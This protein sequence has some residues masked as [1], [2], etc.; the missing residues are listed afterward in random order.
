MFSKSKT[1]SLLAFRPLQYKFTP[2]FISYSEQ[3][4]NYEKDV[5]R[6]FFHII[7][8]QIIQYL[9]SKQFEV[10]H[11]GG[12]NDMGIDIRVLQISQD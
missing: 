3:G 5:C 6:Y 8:A 10:V 7:I 11:S 1:L 4:T 9:S 2:R 12:P